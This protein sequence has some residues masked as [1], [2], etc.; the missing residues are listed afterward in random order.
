MTMRFIGSVSL[1]L[2][3]FKN[4]TASRRLQSVVDQTILASANVLSIE[5]AATPDRGLFVATAEA[6]DYR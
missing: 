1:A 4:S 2:L 3:V 5:F 6:L